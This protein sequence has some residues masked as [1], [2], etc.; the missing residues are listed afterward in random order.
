MPIVKRKN[1][2]KMP[3]H[4]YSFLKDKPLPSIVEEF[5]DVARISVDFAEFAKVKNSSILRSN[6]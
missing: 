3:K 2:V 4:N 5:N 1:K 6:S